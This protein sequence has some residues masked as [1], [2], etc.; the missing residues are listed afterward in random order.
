MI[1]WLECPTERAGMDPMRLAHAVDLVAGRGAT[2][3]LCV[4][5]ARELVLDRCYGC[6]PDSLFWI[7]SARKPFVALAVHLL[8]ELRELSLD[9]PVAR[10]WPAFAQRGKQAITIRHVLAH[11][12]GIPRARGTLRD[13]A[14]ITSC[15]RSTRLLERARPSWPAGQVPAYQRGELRLRARRGRPPRH[16]HAGRGFP[17]R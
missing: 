13:G 16:R 4:L 6:R 1:D 7:F 2:A 8:A 14:V 11:R 15:Q 12:A 9:D 10:Y 5:R 3:L 17:C